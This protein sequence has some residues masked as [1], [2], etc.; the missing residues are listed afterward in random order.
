VGVAAQPSNKHSSSTAVELQ[1]KHANGHGHGAGAMN[2]TPPV[3]SLPAPLP[4]KRGLTKHVVTRWYRAP[5]VSVVCTRASVAFAAL[6][7]AMMRSLFPSLVAAGV[8]RTIRACVGKD[9]VSYTRVGMT[10]ASRLVFLGSECDACR[11]E[12]AYAVSSPRLN[13]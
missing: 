12:V 9:Q 2:I 8:W 13:R 11:R 1:A 10:A 4:L 3:E 5:E 6:V 7:C